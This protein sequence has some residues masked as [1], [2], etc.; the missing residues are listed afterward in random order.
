MSAKEQIKEAAIKIIA[1]KGLFNT[2]TA[3]IAQEAQI[4]LSSLYNYYADKSQIMDD[5]FTSELQKR[6]AFYVNIKNWHMDWFLK[7]NGIINFHLQ[8]IQKEPDL[9]A[10]IITEQINPVFRENESVRKFSQLSL[11]IADILQQAI[12]EKKII[13][14]DVQATSLII[15]GFIDKIISEYLLTKDSKHIEQ[16]IASFGLL[17]KKA[18]E[19]TS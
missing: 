10:I 11:I 15:C 9:A 2:T 19:I 8:E 13:P 12:S 1:Q 5:I 4:N 14:C 18:L 6:Y 3:E 7:I 17:L 16:A